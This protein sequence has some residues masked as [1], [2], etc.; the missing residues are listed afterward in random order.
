MQSGHDP[1]AFAA[2][3]PSGGQPVALVICKD[4]QAFVDSTANR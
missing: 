4:Y 3:A 2:L 1:L